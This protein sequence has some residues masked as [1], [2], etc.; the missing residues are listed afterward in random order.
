M[1]IL[2]LSLVTNT[3]EYFFRKPTHHPALVCPRVAGFSLWNT[4]ISKTDTFLS[5]AYEFRIKN[6]IHVISKLTIEVFDIEFSCM[7]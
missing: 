7:F 6:V 2:G 1:N 3:L 4:E 5:R